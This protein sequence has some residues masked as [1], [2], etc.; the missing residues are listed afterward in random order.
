MAAAPKLR[1]HH[2]TAPRPAPSRLWRNI[3]ALMLLGLCV[4]AY[5]TAQVRLA[6]LEAEKRQLMRRLADVRAENTMLL[7]Q[8]RTACAP[9][10]IAEAAD[11]SGLQP[12]AGVDTVH[13]ASLRLDQPGSRSPG[14]A[15]FAFAR[16]LYARLGLISEAPREAEAAPA[17]R[18]S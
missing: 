5:L 18:P 6:V 14:Q 17:D 4:G 13:P 8:I 10:R 2:R 1:S 9:E 11:R 16:S 12:P 3:T 15:L 7:K